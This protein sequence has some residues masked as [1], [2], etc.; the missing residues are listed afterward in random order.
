M[1]DH[2]VIAPGCNLFEAMKSYLVKD[3]KWKFNG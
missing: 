1:V 3:S 2:R